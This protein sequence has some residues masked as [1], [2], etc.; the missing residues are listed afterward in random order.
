MVI[1]ERFGARCGQAERLRDP[2]AEGGGVQGRGV[3]EIACAE[4]AGGEWEPLLGLYQVD[5]ARR[6]RHGLPGPGDHGS[7]LGDT[8]P[9]VRL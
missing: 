7:G 8:L 6:L 3:P 2:A 5:R 9:A 1:C 4:Q